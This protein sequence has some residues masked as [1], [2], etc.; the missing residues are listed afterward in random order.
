MLGC[1]PLT[2]TFGDH[3]RG[4]CTDGFRGQFRWEPFKSKHPQHPLTGLVPSLLLVERNYGGSVMSIWDSECRHEDT[5]I[6][7]VSVRDSP[8]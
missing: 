6:L 7:L 1:Q 4:V 3:T 2:S 5:G 8:R